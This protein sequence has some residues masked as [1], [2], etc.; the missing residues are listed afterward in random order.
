M[1]LAIHKSSSSEQLDSQPL[2]HTPESYSGRTASV[3]SIQVHRDT[4]NIFVV[5]VE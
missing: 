4:S 1:T 2:L 5:D 3:I